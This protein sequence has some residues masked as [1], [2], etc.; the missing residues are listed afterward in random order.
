MFS[1][2]TNVQTISDLLKMP[3]HHYFGYQIFDLSTEPDKLEKIAS[4]LQV[5]LIY[6]ILV[7]ACPS[8]SCYNERSCSGIKDTECI[9]LNQNREESVRIY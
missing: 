1:D 5:N 7:N 4:S 2:N 9:I 8:I 6:S 3:L